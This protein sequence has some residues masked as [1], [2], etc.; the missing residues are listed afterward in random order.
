MLPFQFFLLNFSLVYKD[1]EGGSSKVKG[2]GD[3]DYV[4]LSFVFIGFSHL[5]L[6]NR[7]FF[8]SN[9]CDF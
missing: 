7:F 4:R 6:I 5:I 9:E 2:G 1:D 3:Y 8:F